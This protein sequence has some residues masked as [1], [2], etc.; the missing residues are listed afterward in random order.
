M[1]ESVKSYQ[2]PIHPLTYNRSIGSRGESR[3]MESLMS[4]ARQV[5]VAGEILNLLVAE[6]IGLTRI[7][8]KGASDRTFESRGHIPLSTDT[9]EPPQ[10]RTYRLQLSTP[11]FLYNLTFSFPTYGILCAK[12]STLALTFCI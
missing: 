11:P 10:S 8:L 9:G 5:D 2:V 6:D 1:A 7:T 12:R 3:S 4:V